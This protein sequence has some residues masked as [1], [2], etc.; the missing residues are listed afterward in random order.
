MIEMQEL[1]QLVVDRTA[2]DLHIKAGE[3]QSCASL[4]N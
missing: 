3:P 4:A 2:S 1:L